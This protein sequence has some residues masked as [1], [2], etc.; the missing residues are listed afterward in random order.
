M[1]TVHEIAIRLKDRVLVLDR[2]LDLR[3]MD[4]S[5][6]S[7]WYCK[8]HC[9]RGRHYKNLKQGPGWSFPVDSFG[10][11]E[12]T[13]EKSTDFSTSLPPNEDGNKEE[14]RTSETT[15]NVEKTTVVPLS[16]K[17]IESL[18]A[19]KKLV[20]VPVAV[21]V[22]VPT[23]PKSALKSA[24]K[25]ALK[26]VA[27]IIPPLPPK[28]PKSAPKSVPKDRP[29]INGYE[30]DLPDEIRKYFRHYEEA[31]FSKRQH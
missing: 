8:F 10:T 4:V 2:D 14:K 25:P 3:N 19:P 18:V 9:W 1:E 12:N 24:L 11:L 21:P 7:D 27:P 15:A 13:V 6:G 23:P 20:H 5:K 28:P 29:F 26:P 31:I 30:I 16:H 17:E 22:S